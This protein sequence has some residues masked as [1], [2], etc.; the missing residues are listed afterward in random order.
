MGEE[1]RWMNQWELRKTSKIIRVKS[2]VSPFWRVE[3]EPEV[4]PRTYM[5]NWKNDFSKPGPPFILNMLTTIKSIYFCESNQGYTRYQ[6]NSYEITTN[7]FQVGK[8]NEIRNVIFSL[9]YG[10]SSSA[11]R[12]KLGYSP[13]WVR[14]DIQRLLGKPCLNKHRF[15]T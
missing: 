11:L 2:H 1:E 14:D 13:S 9:H 5:L 7:G 3:R 12:P 4:R 6:N 10:K 15:V 8:I